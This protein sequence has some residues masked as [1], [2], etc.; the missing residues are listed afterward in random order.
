MEK[1]DPREAFREALA[2]EAVLVAA[3]A[4][5]AVDMEPSLGQML[6]LGR[7]LSAACG[8]QETAMMLEA[9]LLGYQEVAIDIP[10]ERKAMGFASPFPV[11][12]LD[13]G[14]SRSGGDFFG[15]PGKI[16]S[17]HPHHRA[18]NRRASDRLGSNPAGGS[19]GAQGPSQR[20]H[21]GVRNDG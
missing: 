13:L 14:A 9:E 5:Q 2:D 3:R 18:A 6:E 7:A 4:I 20:D 17:G 16:L 15:Q 1:N 21:R 12:A 19:V 10:P 8:A 11:R